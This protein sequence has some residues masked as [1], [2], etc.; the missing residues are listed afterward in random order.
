[1]R[2]KPYSGTRLVLLFASKNIFIAG[3]L[4]VDKKKFRYVFN[5]GT[6]KKYYEPD[7][8][9]LNIKKKF[10]IQPFKRWKK[11]KKNKPVRSIKNYPVYFFITLKGFIHNTYGIQR[12]LIDEPLLRKFVFFITSF[13]VKLKVVGKLSK[14]W[15]LVYKGFGNNIVKKKVYSYKTAK[16][17]RE[18]FIQQ[19]LLFRFNVR[20]IL[21]IRGRAY[22]GCKLA[23]P[24][25]KKMVVPLQIRFK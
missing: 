5:E 20:S 25:R 19:L 21:E 3:K 10:F 2:Y 9:F 1:M 6:R 17:L 24:R 13:L 11:G 7:N 8:T 18:Y 22:N 12:L 23:K 4:L 14:K 16:R 15:Q